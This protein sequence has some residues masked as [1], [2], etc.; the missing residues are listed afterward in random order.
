[1]R[2]NV[3]ALFSMLQK[4]LAILNSKQKRK[5]VLVFICVVIGSI[6]ELLGVSC[7]LPFINSLENVLKGY[8]TPSTKYGFKNI[9]RWH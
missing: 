1:M 3:K 8:N 6:F 4:L 9:L 7:I 2:Q 5:C